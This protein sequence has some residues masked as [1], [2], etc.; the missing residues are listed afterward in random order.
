MTGASNGKSRWS[1]DG[2][3]GASSSRFFQ[4]VDGWRKTREKSDWPAVFILV[5]GA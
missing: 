3:G 1:A 5:P 2:D 4:C